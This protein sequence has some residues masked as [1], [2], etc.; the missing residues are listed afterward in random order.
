MLNKIK[1]GLKINEDF[2]QK[3]LIWRESNKVYVISKL[4]VYML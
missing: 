3:N 4:L 1:I 2:E